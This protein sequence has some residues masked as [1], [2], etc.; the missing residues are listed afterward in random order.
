[1]RRLDRWALTGL[2]FAGACGGPIATVSWDRATPRSGDVVGDEVRIQSSADGGTFP[3][4]SFAPTI[5]RGDGY[6]VE[7]RIRYAGVAGDGYLEMWSEFPGEGRY[8]SRTLEPAG[9]QG[10]ITGDSDWREFQL[11]FSTNGGPSPARVDINLVL[12]GSGTVEIG[13]LR[14]VSLGGSAWWSD[15]TAGLLG[16]SAGL[17][18]GLLGATVGVRAARRKARR[19]VLST[20]VVLV[21]L[22]VAS[23]VAGTV[24]LVRH[25]PYAVVYPLFLLGVIGVGVFASGYRGVR[26]GFEEAELRKMHALDAM[27]TGSG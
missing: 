18:I 19:F 21:C 17:M 6:V 13:P 7:G 25:Q 20:M 16:A 14:V 26:R 12:P 4:V 11:P 9:P 23:L 24:A 10:R 22:G 1:M 2:V 3:L 27:S 15:R 8:F 5:P